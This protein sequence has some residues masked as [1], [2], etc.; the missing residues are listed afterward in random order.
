MYASSQDPWV[1][2]SY[3]YIYIHHLWGRSEYG[4]QICT[5][6]SSRAGETSPNVASSP[7]SQGA[8]Q[9]APW[10]FSHGVQSY[11]GAEGCFQWC[12]LMAQWS[13]YRNALVQQC[14]VRLAVGTRAIY[15]AVL[16]IHAKPGIELWNSC[17]SGIHIPPWDICTNLCYMLPRGHLIWWMGT[18]LG[19]PVET[20]F[21]NKG[22]SKEGNSEKESQ[23]FQLNW[24][25]SE[26]DGH[27]RCA[28]S[29]EKPGQTRN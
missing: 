18:V 13:V 22:W 7:L 28:R 3:L 1:T 19:I 26:L 25:W 5:Q 2:L 20:I 6:N 27:E 14:L 9:T 4:T 8:W 29:S 11:G 17:I 15:L 21:K 10:L 23:N 24:E 16:G 12:D